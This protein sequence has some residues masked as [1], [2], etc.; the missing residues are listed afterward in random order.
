VI[1]SCVNG[2]LLVVFNI[3][4]VLSIQ[5]FDPERLFDENVDDAY[6]PTTA[7]G[8]PNPDSGAKQKNNF[9]G[10]IGFYPNN[11]FVI[12]KGEDE[13]AA[14]AQAYTPAAITRTVSSMKLSSRG[15]KNIATYA[16]SAEV[17]MSH[18]S[19]APTGSRE[20]TNHVYTDPPTE[21][22]TSD[23]NTYG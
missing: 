13:S 21:P 3:A 14:E 4:V 19:P 17:D 16:F 5:K 11:A 9:M 12:M 8:V 2:I 15:K 18:Y 10:T 7:T 20:P 22:K 23:P 6:D 1:A